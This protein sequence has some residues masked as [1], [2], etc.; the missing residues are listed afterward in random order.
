VIRLWV[1]TAIVVPAGIVAA[2]IDEAATQ[3]QIIAI[4]V[5]ILVRFMILET[6]WLSF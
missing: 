5:I 4:T 3:Q 1:V 6:W 2:L